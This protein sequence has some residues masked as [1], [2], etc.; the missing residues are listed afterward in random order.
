MVNATQLPETLLGERTRP[1][2]RF[3]DET[4]ASDRLERLRQSERERAAPEIWEDSKMDEGQTIVGKYRLNS[5]LGMGGM[6]SVW[7]ATNVFTD[8]KFAIK[9]MLPQVARTPHP[10]PPFILDAQDPAP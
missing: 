3:L 1:C 8:R 6:A 4:P 10:A 2:R 5:L 7:S 9:F